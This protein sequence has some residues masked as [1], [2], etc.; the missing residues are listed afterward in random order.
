[1]TETQENLKKQLLHFSLDIYE[2]DWIQANTF[3]DWF[4]KMTS[5][6]PLPVCSLP[7]PPATI[8][9]KAAARFW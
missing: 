7:I 8:T 1:M 6:A 2:R 3:I 5:A 4:P 9:V